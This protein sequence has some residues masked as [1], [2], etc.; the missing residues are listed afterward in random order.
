MCK[1]LEP[2]L[3]PGSGTQNT[4]EAGERQGRGRLNGPSE[5]PSSDF[6]VANPR[7]HPTMQARPE[8]ETETQRGDTKDQRQSPH[9]KPP[10]QES[11]PIILPSIAKT[12]VFSPGLV[13]GSASDFMAWQAVMMSCICRKLAT[14]STSSTFSELRLS[15]A[16]Y[17][18]SS[19]CP[20][21]AKDTDSHHGPTSRPGTSS[22]PSCSTR[23]QD[24]GICEKQS[25]RPPSPHLLCWQRR[26]TWGFS[27]QTTASKQRYTH[28]R[29]RV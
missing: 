29:Q 16:V 18:N 19:T 22:L 20:R 17:I 13:A 3:L 8:E 14:A 10:A 4:G 25:G 11:L 7:Q 5:R 26:A 9:R 1:G 15:L 24:P 12:S 23:R 2:G 28:R 21:P 6:T 27:A